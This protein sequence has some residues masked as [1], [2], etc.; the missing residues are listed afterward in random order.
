MATDLLQRGADL[1]D[2]FRASHLARLATY[3]R[4][5]ESVRIAAATGATVMEVTDESGVSVRTRQM[6]F[7]VS[8]ADLSLAGQP[9]EPRV[10]DRITMTDGGRALVFEVLALPGGEHFRTDPTGR[11]FRIH[12]KQVTEAAG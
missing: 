1:V 8:V 12:A 9:T 7:I 5:G 4:D 10:G 2:G 3:R 6:D 11:M